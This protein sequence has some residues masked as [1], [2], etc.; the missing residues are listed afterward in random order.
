MPELDRAGCRATAP[1]RKTPRSRPA[2]SGGMD[3]MLARLPEEFREVLI[4]REMEDLS[5]RE[6][7]EITGAPIGTVMSRLA[8]ARALL[9]EREG[10]AMSCNESPAH[11]KLSG[12]RTARRGRGEAERHLETCA[13]CQALAAG[14]RRCSAMPCAAPP[15][16]AAPELLRAARAG[17]AG[18]ETALS[19]SRF[20]DR[21][22]QRRR[23]HRRW[24]RRWRCSLFLPPSAASLTAVGRRR[25]WPRPDQRP[26]HHG[27]LQQPSHGQALAGGACRAFRRR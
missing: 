16:H 13:E 1:A 23:R 14:C 19:R 15:R 8:R 2:A 21:R 7:A 22:G 24:R 10:S 9:R 18:R 3:A 27:R 25:P 4:L 6:I 17:A 11:P 12:R 20:L 5:Y 26:D